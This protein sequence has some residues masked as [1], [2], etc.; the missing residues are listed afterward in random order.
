MVYQVH[1][2][3][4]GK[5]GVLAAAMIAAIFAQI[6]AGGFLEILPESVAGLDGLL[7]VTHLWLF[8]PLALMLLS[9]FAKAFIRRREE[10]P[11]LA[12]PALAPALARHRACASIPVVAITFTGIFYAYFWQPLAARLDNLWLAIPIHILT[13][14]LLVLATAI[15]MGGVGRFLLKVAVKRGIRSPDTMVNLTGGVAM[16]AFMGLLFGIIIAN[17]YAVGVFEFLGN[18]AAVSIPIAMLPYAAAL[19]ADE[20]RWLALSGWL[21]VSTA[22]ALWSVRATYRWSFSAQ[23]EIPIDLVIP[24]KHVYRPA[25]TGRSSRWLP[26]GVAAFWRKDI[27]V[28]YSREP[29]RYLFLQ[30]NILWWSIM[31][32]FLAMALRNRGTISAAFADTIPVVVA[33]FTTAFVAMQNG[34]N[35]LGREGTEIT[36]LRPIFSGPQLLGRKLL[37]NLAY[38][39][40][41]GV[42]YSFVLD[43]A[44][45]TASVDVSFSVLLAYAVGAGST[46]TCLATAVGFLL[47]DFERSRSSLPGSSTLGMVGFSFSAIVL[48]SLTGTAHLLLTAGSFDVSAY[49]GLLAF[50]FS[51]AAV[52]IV[53]TTAG[54]LRQY[55][56]LEI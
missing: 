40:A 47:P 51:C 16:A 37:P 11:L 46:F 20:G 38:V 12:H 3:L 7:L 48:S 26:K 19:A 14:A 52:G 24:A 30:F 15:L 41:H 49:A 39:L 56:G 42:A 31:A 54:G 27:A 9:Q 18:S 4:H 1:H 5:L 22:A 43:T 35:A 13:T 44:A 36:W 34:V 33:L 28:P 23:R 45:A 25:F 17:E 2:T 21:V 6:V 50:A 8:A 32:V 53:L 10:E 55:G 29:K